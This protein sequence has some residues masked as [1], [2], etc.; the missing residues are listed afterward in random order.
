MFYVLLGLAIPLFHFFILSVVLVLVH[1]LL[2]ALFFLVFMFLLFV[3]SFYSSSPCSFLCSPSSSLLY[4]SYCSFSSSSPCFTFYSV[5]LFLFPYSFSCSFPHRYKICSL[6][7][8]FPKSS[9]RLANRS[10]LLRAGAD[11]VCDTKC[12]LGIAAGAI[13]LLVVVAFVVAC[14]R[15]DRVQKA[16]RKKFADDAPDLSAPLSD[17]V[18]RGILQENLHLNFDMTTTLNMHDKK[19]EV[20]DLSSFQSD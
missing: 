17:Y 6:L 14:W 10:T 12:M 2:I 13:F 15:T 16:V 20:R 19:Y 9:K 1:L 8:S 7:R 18:D 5:L 3:F 11:I 4:S